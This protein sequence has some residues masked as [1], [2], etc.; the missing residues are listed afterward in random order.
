MSFVKFPPPRP[1]TKKETLDSLDHW[2]SQ[3][4]TFFKRDDTFRP[5]LSSAFTWDPTMVKFGFTG[6]DA[7]EKSDDFG[8]F[9]NVLS[10]FLPHSYLTS[11]ISSDT[12]CWEDVW[13][14][15]YTHYNCKISGDTLLDFEALNRE[16]DENYQQFYERLLQHTRLHM[17][18]AQSEVGKLKITKADEMSI[19]VMNMVALQ[20]L[21]KSERNLINIVKTEYSTEL[22]SGIQLAHLVPTIA[23]NIDNLL[24]RYSSSSVQKV[25]VD[26]EQD[27]DDDTEDESDVRFNQQDRRYQGKGGQGR[28]SS[29]GGDR[30]PF[31]SSA[32]GRSFTSD[33][34]NSFCPGCKK[35]AE[36]QNASIDFHHLPAKCPRRFV[37]RSI[38]ED[39][40]EDDSEEFGNNN[41][42]YKTGQ[43]F[44]SFQSELDNLPVAD[45]SNP[46]RVVLSPH[47]SST[48][49]KLEI[50]VNGNTNV[51]N[52]DNSSL[53]TSTNVNKTVS[54]DTMAWKSIINMVHRI[55]ERKHLWNSPIR[56]EKSPTVTATV[57]DSEPSPTTIDEGSE[58]NVIDH[59]FCL[60]WKIKFTPTLHS[61]RAAGSSSMPVKGQTVDDVVLRLVDC[62]SPIKWTLGRC[63][64]VENLGVN[65]LIGEPGKLDNCIRTDPLRRVVETLD[66]KGRS[67]IVN[68]SD[69]AHKKSALI[70][71]TTSQTLYVGD[72]LQIQVPRELKSEKC[73]SIH[74]HKGNQW[75]SPTLSQS[76]GNNVILKNS[77]KLPV[78]I[79]KGEHLA[80]LRAMSYE[81]PNT[82]KV[83]DK[84]RT[85]FSDLMPSPNLNL[86]ESHI[87]D[88]RI[89]PD[90][91]L[92]S[93]WKDRFTDICHKFKDVFN[94]NPGK[95]NG[96]YGDIDCS[97]NF[98]SNPPPSVKARI[99]TYPHDK[100]QLMGN[101][102]DDMERMGVLQTPEDAGVVP[103]FVVPSMLQPKTEPG[104][105]RLVS[106]FTPLN[107]HIKKLPTVSPTIDEAKQKLAKYKYN[108]ELDLSNY[109]WQQGMKVADK[110]YLGTMHPFKGLRIYAVEPQ[111]LRNASEHAYERLARIYGDLCADE[112]MTR[113][114]DG[115]YV[116][117]DTLPELELNFNE[118]LS[119]ARNCG[120]TFKPK[121]VV[122]V[123]RFTILFGWKKTDDGWRPLEHAV[124]PLTK[125]QLP[126]TAK[127]LRSFIGSYK[128]MTECIK[129]YAV[130]LSPLE[131]AAGGK[132]SAT[133]IQWTEELIKHFETAK[134]ALKDIKTI[135]VPKPSDKLDIY[136][137][138]SK[139]KEA[140]GGELII[141]RTDEDGTV[142][143]LLGGHFS[144]KLNKHQKNW[145]PCEGEALGVR[146]TAQHFSPYIRENLNIATI[147]TDN[148]P[149]VHAWKRLK[150]GA[151]SSSARVAAF[152][153][154]LSTLTVDIV[155]TPGK[156]I[157]LSDYNSRHPNSCPEQR[158]QICQFAAKFEM[159]GD[160]VIPMV[161]SISVEEVLKGSVKMPFY[162]RSAWLKTQREDRA[163]RMLLE[164]IKTSQSPEPKKTKGDYTTLKRLHGMYRSGTLKVSSDGLV[165]ISAS[166]PFGNFHE[167]ISVPTRF[168]PGLIHALHIRLDHPSKPQLQ[169]LVSRYFYSP[170]QARITDE[171]CDSC[172]TCT[173]LRKL[174]KELFS[175]STTATETFGSSFSADVIKKDCQLVF[176]CR[177][178][179]SQFTTSKIISDET[180]DCLRDCVVSAVIEFIPEN[181]AT[182]QVDC[183]TGF[184]KLASEWSMDGSILKKLGIMIDLGRTHNV[185][186]NP[187]AENCVKEF[188]KERLRL[189]PSG[190]QITEIERAQIT[191]NMNSRI[192]E[193]GLTAKEMAFN[194][195]QI[196]NNFK[197]VSDLKL[198]EKQVQLRENR[199]PIVPTKCKHKFKI[200]DNVFLK[201][202]V[203]KLRG[204]EIHKIIKI[205]QSGSEKM[206]TIRKN[207]NKFM[208]KDYEV[209]LTEIFPIN[210]H[211]LVGTDLGIDD[212]DDDETDATKNTETEIY[213]QKPTSSPLKETQT[214]G[215]PKRKAAEKQK[216]LLKDL[217]DNSALMVTTKRVPALNQVPT[218]GFNY[219]DWVALL[220]NDDDEQSKHNQQNAALPS[221][222]MNK[223]RSILASKNINPD[224]C[225]EEVLDVVHE[226]INL[227]TIGAKIEMA[228]VKLQTW[229]RKI[230]AKKYH[231]AAI[232]I[233]KWFRELLIRRSHNQLSWDHSPQDPNSEANFAW[234]DELEER[235]PEDFIRLYTEELIETIEENNEETD[236]PRVRLH[237]VHDDEPPELDLSV[238]SDEEV[239][240]PTIPTPPVPSCKLNRTGAFRRKD[241][242]L[243]DPDVNPPPATSPTTPLLPEHVDLERAQYLRHAFDALHQTGQRT[244]YNNP[245]SPRLRRSNRERKEN[246]KVMGD[247]WTR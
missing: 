247:S 243:P 173:S 156:D 65:L 96:F 164:L 81:V 146:L 58:I 206:A 101:L 237:R 225:V 92:S 18:P 85:D 91:Q 8:D 194:R 17:A 209:K 135:Y 126:S 16:S 82:C 181:G 172:V 169:K 198:S 94:P 79:K 210:S 244:E 99:P 97:L 162:Q 231:L 87:Q 197:P 127:Q 57:N 23:P 4:R 158:C 42:D 199:H 108:V 115:L 128:Q 78:F 113:M 211:S 155:H 5:F 177:E 152:L 170:G 216:L 117:G 245:P 191:K 15:I 46:A 123:P 238:T 139:S 235:R 192:R 51:D 52:C 137:D 19:T 90:N 143:K 61:A 204:R 77:S 168:F 104:Q 205:Y 229:F 25:A 215:R 107:I 53:V 54:E 20:W 31:R 38:Q 10:G 232:R 45:Q 93:D 147:H 150:T 72:S 136:S 186:K 89:D 180:A 9:L 64:V 189:S 88:I 14:I 71:A 6:A 223:L 27:E 122:I 160:N 201:K 185:N 200:G 76:L 100:L 161:G 47:Q 69:K 182:I 214:P 125:A 222:G 80:E 43:S 44:K 103:T 239:F 75:L 86:E 207:E 106:D 165:T 29:R 145:W 56:K 1:L 187:I 233:Q 190:G 30:K 37:V 236:E 67:I 234:T 73:L 131:A 109:F 63:I 84:A 39:F 159:I 12:K 213:E 195:D 40:H 114:A 179:L 121:K 132:S 110:P 68:Y 2:R 167:A 55:E 48:T 133:L 83:Y 171:V 32:P 49:F 134:E 212:D 3:F 60:R 202:D 184:Q 118:V 241:R 221:D 196:S 50:V 142:R 230:L 220:D 203:S 11:R 140:V 138:Y 166:D 74:P 246:P 183:A 174:P 119:R 219:D 41:S 240:L 208:A 124:S 111:G 70:R 218:H 153:T 105:W 129:D 102:M 144:G 36:N 188:L 217:I 62:V 26:E 226:Y 242:A 24:S 157:P 33:R 7:Q 21:R 154:G 35:I 98:A 163:H 149:T 59:N 148:L 224:P 228:A 116:L 22:K 175:E 34:K 227:H 28:F 95:Y 176:V 141:T 178:K 13:N 151:F 66:I 130:L 120:L 112:K 193:R